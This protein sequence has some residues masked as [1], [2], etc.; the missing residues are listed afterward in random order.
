MMMISGSAAQTSRL[1][2]GKSGRACSSDGS[3]FVP[4]VVGLFGK[5]R[6]SRWDQNVNDRDQFASRGGRGWGCSVLKGG[7][8]SEGMST[9]EGERGRFVCRNLEK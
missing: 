9:S 6:W 5:K 7:A 8:K 3:S 4:G 2:T 1:C